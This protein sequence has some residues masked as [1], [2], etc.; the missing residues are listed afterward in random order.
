M[1]QQEHTPLLIVLF[2]PT[3]SG[4]TS[5]SVQLAQALE[6]EILSADARQFYQEMSIGTAKP[7][8]E[9]MEGVPHHFVD[10]R[11][12]KDDYSVGDFERDAIAFLDDY[13]KTKNI[14][15]LVGGSGFYMRAVCEGLDNYPDVPP[16]IRQTLNTIYE[17]QGILPL[18]E[19]LAQCDPDYYAK[20][21]TNNPKR[22]IR[23]LEIYRATGQPFSSFHQQRKAIR[24]FNILKLGLR[25]ER[26][27]LYHRINQRVDNM[28]DDGLLEEVKSLYSYKHLNALQTVGYQEIFDYLDNKISLEKAIE[29]VKRNS[30]RYAKRQMTWLRREDKLNWIDCPMDAQKA[31]T[32]VQSLIK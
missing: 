13:F 2:G 6:A 11:S 32:F 9:E 8:L 25:W 17:E 5:F 27:Q 4:K 10:C 28:L 21:D 24:P 20:V 26:E 1:T 12:I 31:V 23:A 16:N 3:A 14:A 30:R 29:L 19:E 7:T 15:I 18:Q 22:L